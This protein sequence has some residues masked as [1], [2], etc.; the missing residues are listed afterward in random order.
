MDGFVFDLRTIRMLCPVL[1]FPDED[2]FTLY[3]TVQLF[4]PL[5]SFILKF[6]HVFDR[7]R[8]GILYR[9]AH[10][11]I[12]LLLSDFMALLLYTQACKSLAIKGLFLLEQNL[13][14][15]VLFCCFIIL[16]YILSHNMLCF[17]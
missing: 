5:N 17:V 14:R 4:S 2:I 6:L 13:V 11:V 9:E 15:S 1:H 12:R 7:I 16:H 3:V 10:N 8:S